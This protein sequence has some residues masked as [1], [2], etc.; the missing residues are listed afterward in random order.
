MWW[1]TGFW[2]AGKTVV[3]EVLSSCIGGMGRKMR[4]QTSLIKRKERWK[5]KQSIPAKLKVI[6]G[7][8]WQTSTLYLLNVDVFGGAA[9]RRIMKATKHSTSMYMKIIVSVAFELK[10]KDL[11]FL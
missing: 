1:E 2:E 4:L 6:Q 3:L 11:Q 8:E 7:I 5:Q 9:F 10:Q